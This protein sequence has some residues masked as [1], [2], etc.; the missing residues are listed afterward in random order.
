MVFLS[1][2]YYASTAATGG[3]CER[4]YSKKYP[5]RGYYVLCSLSHYYLYS[6]FFFFL[7]F[8]SCLFKTCLN[9]YTHACI[10]TRL[11]VCTVPPPPLHRS[12]SILYLCINSSV[13]YVYTH[14][15]FRRCWEISR[16]QKQQRVL[17]VAPDR[18]VVMQWQIRKNI[19]V[20]SYCIDVFCLFFLWI[21]VGLHVN[22]CYFNAI[23]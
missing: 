13:Y 8:I 2:R 12:E 14:P 19:D 3:V 5:R 10:Y 21:Q 7:L 9:V 6:F 1:I 16:Q 18:C 20:S 11:G 4:E 23:L 17:C 15:I 22:G